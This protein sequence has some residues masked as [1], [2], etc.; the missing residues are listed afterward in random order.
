MSK[1]ANFLAFFQI[2]KKELK[3]QTAK[4]LITDSRRGKRQGR[5]T[6]CTMNEGTGK[7]VMPVAHTEEQRG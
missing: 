5:R 2:F 1:T 4:Y 6:G 3:G 7:G